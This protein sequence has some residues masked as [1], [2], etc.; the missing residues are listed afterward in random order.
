MRVS[1][2]DPDGFVFRS[3]ARIYRC[4]YPHAVDDLRS[5][6]GSPFAIAQMERGTLAGVTSSPSAPEPEVSTAMPAGSMILEHRGITFPNFPYEWAPEMLHRAA[7]LTL[8]LA[9]D[10]LAEGFGLK[11]GTP[12][13]IMFEGVTPIFLDVLSFEH[14]DPLDPAWRPYAQFVQTFL[15]PLLANRYL[16]LQ[17]DEILLTHR[18]GLE[19]ERLRRLC[20]FWLSLRP[21]FLSL[22]TIPAWLSQL[23]ENSSSDRFQTRRAKDAGEAKF[24]LRRVFARAGRMLRRIPRQRRSTASRYMESSHNYAAAE[25]ALKEEAVRKALAGAG[26]RSV[27][28]IGCNTGHFSLL[29]ART[30]ARVVAIDRDAASVG[31]LWEAAAGR[32]VDILPLVV[33]IARPPGASG[34]ANREHPSF[35]ERARGRFDCVLMLALLHHL[36]VNERVPL[37]SL[38]E[39]I[40]ELTVRWAVIEYIDPADAQFQRI[41]RGR[42]ALHRDVTAESFEAAAGR[43]FRIVDVRAVTPTRRIYTLEKAAS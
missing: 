9:E 29:A 37:D 33:D 1:F 32:N 2:R 27:L 13:N 28:D 23:T 26:A 12:Y 5:F 36:I 19:P 22:V 25:L 18:E 10:A 16:G 24:L 34:W 35:L 7:A 42:E 21:P 17:L 11:D 8:Q 39:L 3:G 31:E 30:G 38:F 4:V 20:S 6:L 43:H 41:L 40:A 14:R 15:Y